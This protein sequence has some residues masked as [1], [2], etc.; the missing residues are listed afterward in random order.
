VRKIAAL[1]IVVL[2]VVLGFGLLLERS[3]HPRGTSP[4]TADAPRGA[5]TV[6][7]Q[8]GNLRF[9]YAADL[10]TGAR[11]VEVPSRPFVADE[12]PDGVGPA[13]THVAFDGFAGVR[14]RSSV[15]AAID[16]YPTADF[17]RAEFGAPDRNLP[18]KEWTLLQEMLA[19]PA[20][21]GSSSQATA[22]LMP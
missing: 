9:S 2:L 6:A 13:H 10:A 18:L 7:F 17:E 19:A 3:R 22:P 15:E 11:G 8:H 20:G 4:D 1:A 16:V 14:S 21:K 12:V 5:K